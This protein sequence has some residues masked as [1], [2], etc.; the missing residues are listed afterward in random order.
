MASAH[1]PELN[2]PGGSPPGLSTTP[3]ALLRAIDG[4]QTGALS[5]VSVGDLLGRGAVALRLG[6]G[7]KRRVLSM[8][9]ELSARNSGVKAPLIFD[10]LMQREGTGSTGVG[11]GVA[12]PHARVPG[13]AKMKGVFVRLSTPVEFEAVDDRPIDLVF[14]LLAPIDCGSEH[15]RALS[16]VARLMRD[17]ELRRLGGAKRSRTAD[18]L[19]AIQALYQLSYSPETRRAPPHQ[20]SERGFGRLEKR[21]SGPRKRRNLVQ[22]RPARSRRGRNRHRAP[23][24]FAPLQRSSGPPLLPGRP[25]ISSSGSRRPRPR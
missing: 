10:A 2:R 17:P 19:N 3:A 12:I 13:L 1:V 21:S 6:A 20:A 5:P 11:H 8:V 15:L 18:L 14:A 4:G 7:D 24:N 23:I 25:S 22:G 16:R 9:A